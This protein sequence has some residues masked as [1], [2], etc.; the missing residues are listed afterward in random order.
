MTTFHPIVL[1]CPHCSTLMSDYELMSYTVHSSISWSDGKCDNGVPDNNQIKICAVCH[2]PFWKADAVLPY[3]PNWDVAG[4]LGGALDIRDLLEPF[5]DGLK[6]FMINFYDD[7]IEDGFA[8]DEER[9]L[10]LRTRLWWSINDI[11]RHWSV[12]RKPGNLRQLI[13][14]IKRYRKQKELNKESMQLF[15][16]YEQM[17]T[18]NL[19]RLI[20]LYIKKGDVDLIYLADMYREKSDFTK[21][22]EVLMKFEGKK[23][24]VYSK[25]KRSINKRN[26]RVFQLN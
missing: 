21:A 6:E 7:L 20:F 3:D 18:K 26:S 5:D 4:E 11:I 9:E 12:S 13:K 19:D 10:Y 24:R 14:M 23:G 22:H 15:S 25:M 17:F 8:D 2:L 1:D 16:K